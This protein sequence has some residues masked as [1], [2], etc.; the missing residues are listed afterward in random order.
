M[1]L[2]SEAE[3]CTFEPQTGSLA[4]FV[5]LAIKKYPGVSKYYTKESVGISEFAKSMGNNF[6]DRHKEVYKEGVLK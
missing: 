5:S 6:Q 1:M 2:E 3:N 4:P